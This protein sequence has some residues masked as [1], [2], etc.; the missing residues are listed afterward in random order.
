MET[1][2]HYCLTST[3]ITQRCSQH[4]QGGTYSVGC[5]Q[6]GNGTCA[7]CTSV[8][9]SGQYN[10]GCGGVSS[11][12]CH[13]CTPDAAKCDPGSFLSECGG[14]RWPQTTGTCT[15]CMFHCESNTTQYT[16]DCTATTRGTCKA[17]ASVCPAGQYVTGCGGVNQNGTCHTCNYCNSTSY[18][19]GCGGTSQGECVPCGTDCMDSTKSPPCLGGAGTCYAKG[20]GNTAAGTCTACGLGAPAAG[21]TAECALNSPGSSYVCGHNCMQGQY[22]AG[23]GASSAGVCTNCVNTAGPGYYFWGCEKN[24][25]GAPVPCPVNTYRTASGGTHVDN[26]TACPSG[27]T[28]GA[29]GSAAC[30]CQAGTYMESAVGPVCKTYPNGYYQEP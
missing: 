15:Y 2:D 25:A 11:G 7:A 19:R 26:C 8:C 24:S 5:G 23:C 10:T 17:C 3:Q 29:T 28:N 6:A 21:Y 14:D 27:D 12:T 4:C 1:F 20:C 9:P 18:A 30:T 16:D 22:A 13:Q